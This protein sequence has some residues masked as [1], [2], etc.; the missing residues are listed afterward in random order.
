VRA[1]DPAH[2]ANAKGSDDTVRT[3]SG[4]CGKRSIGPTFQ[5]TRH[6]VPGRAINR[7]VRLR[8]F[9]QEGFDLPPQ[10]VVGGA[11]ILEESA[12]FLER[13]LSRGIE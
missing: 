7:T 2:T 9:R 13:E 12:A 8:V 6:S 3:E 1:V 5:Q 11:L 10:S 4:S